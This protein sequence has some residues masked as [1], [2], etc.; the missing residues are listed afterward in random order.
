M[1]V[2]PHSHL[3]VGLYHADSAKILPDVGIDGEVYMYPTCFEADECC[4]GFLEYHGIPLVVPIL[5]PP[6]GFSMQL[7]DRGHH[8]YISTGFA[9][10]HFYSTC[11]CPFYG[12][13]AA[14]HKE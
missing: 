1:L 8:P 4:P 3:S 11:F 2:Q 14:H 6:V 5:F 7:L 10:N 13:P 12:V 9:G